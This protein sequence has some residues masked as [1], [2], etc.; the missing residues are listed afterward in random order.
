MHAAMNCICRA[1]N[2]E[3]FDS[4]EVVRGGSE[5]LSAQNGGRNLDGRTRITSLP[6]KVAI[7]HA[8]SRPALA[9]ARLTATISACSTSTPLTSKAL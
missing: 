4:E 5:G 6:T 1:L 2:P 3:R 8:G 9:M 7:T